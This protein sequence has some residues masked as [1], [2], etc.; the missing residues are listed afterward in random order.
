MRDWEQKLNGFLEFNER[1]VLQGK[2][3]ISME[4]AQNWA[5]E[6][7]RLFDEHRRALETQADLKELTD[8]ITSIAEE[9]KE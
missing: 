8:A 3:Q 2:G 4:D 7:Y 9:K 1:E 5:K 6:Q